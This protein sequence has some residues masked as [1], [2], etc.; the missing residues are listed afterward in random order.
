MA[1]IEYARNVCGFK[2]ANTT[3]VDPD[4]KHPV[5]C[6]LPEQEDIKELGGTMRL[7]GHDVLI[8]KNTQAFGLYGRTSAR[9]RFRHRFNVNTKYIDTLEDKG[10]VFSGR[11][12]KKRIMQILELPKSRFH[13]GVQFHPEFTSRPLSPNPLYEGFVKAALGKRGYK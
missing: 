9:E 2:G 6:I 4:T 10:L 8:K 11:A 1:V 3:E 13:I 7:G 12:P 5:I